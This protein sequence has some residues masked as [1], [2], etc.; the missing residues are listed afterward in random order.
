MIKLNE[1]RSERIS[2]T[3]KDYPIFLEDRL[4]SSYPGY[5]APSHFHEDL[6]FIYIKSGKMDYSVNGTTVSLEM[7]EGIFVNSRALHYGFSQKCEQCSFICLLIHPMLLSIS[8]P[9]AETF[10]YPLINNAF[11][12]FIHLKREVFWHESILD[13]IL[14]INGRKGDKCLPAYIVSSALKILAILYDN[15]ELRT[16]CTIREDNDVAL[17]RKML[18]YIERNYMQKI[19][20]EGTSAAS[21][22]Q[23]SSSSPQWHIFSLTDLA[24]AHIFLRIAGSA[25]LILRLNADSQTALTLLDASGN[26]LE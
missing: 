22:L 4:L 23:D 5:A 11:L 25:L 21:F 18:S 10:L 20:L 7:G 19:S 13:E 14:S 17:M 8:G 12:P 6:E 3:F 16:D 1:N 15:L 2:Y 9:F 24:L 26:G